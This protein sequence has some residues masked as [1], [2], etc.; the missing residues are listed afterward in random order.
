MSTYVRIEQTSGGDVDTKLLVMA[1]GISTGISVALREAVQVS[2]GQLNAAIGTMSGGDGMLSNYPRP[3][4][5]HRRMEAKGGVTA[6]SGGGEAKIGPRG[7][8]PIVENDTN[9]HL[10]GFGKA[11]KA[12]SRIAGFTNTDLAGR[13]GNIFSGYSK[14]KVTKAYGGSANS[15]KRLVIGG[16]VVMAP[17]RHPGT[18]GKD[19]WKQT[20]DGPLRAA[21]PRIMRF[22]IV[23]GALRA[24]GG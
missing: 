3:N 15:R 7:P 18:K 11:S 6:S 20:R 5:G 23:K 13:S 4:R 22:P 8:V 16:N 1:A 19:R 17:V 10:I 21:L 14:S 2:E 12:G 9:A 24:F